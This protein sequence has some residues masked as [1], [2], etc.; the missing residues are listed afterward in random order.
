MTRD[1]KEEWDEVE[2]TIGE[3]TKGKAEG[4]GVEEIRD[5][6]EHGICNHRIRLPNYIKTSSHADHVLKSR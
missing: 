1:L 6:P 3:Y 4:C 2:K 5:E